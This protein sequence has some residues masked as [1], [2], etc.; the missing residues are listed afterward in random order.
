MAGL[1]HGSIDMDGLERRFLSAD[2]R[3]E[4]EG[5]GDVRADDSGADSDGGYDDSESAAGYNRTSSAWLG[6]PLEDKSMLT[7]HRPWGRTRSG[8]KGGPSVNTGPKG[9]K[10]DYDEY[11]AH[12]EV[13]RRVKAA[14][15]SAL[16]DRLVSGAKTDTPSIS[17]SAQQ[18]GTR[19]PSTVPV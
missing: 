17:F 3:R 7:T 8:R 1:V 14:E 12:K 4:G 19:P 5:E 13:E 9:V 6:A 11:R 15:R 10:A 16:I 2:I 18:A